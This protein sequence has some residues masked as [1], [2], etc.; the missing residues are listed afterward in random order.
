[1]KKQNYLLVKDNYEKGLININYAK[2]DGFKFNPKNQVEYEGI[3][4]NEMVIINPSFIENVLKRKTKKKLELYLKFIISLID[5]ESSATSDDLREALN[6]LVRYKSIVENKYR[7]YLE[8]RYMNVLLKKIDLLEQELKNKI[9][10]YKEPVME[11][12]KKTR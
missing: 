2:L 8:E 3:M 4:V 6:G 9:L 11:E 5:D 1:M 10:Y 7:R 12:S